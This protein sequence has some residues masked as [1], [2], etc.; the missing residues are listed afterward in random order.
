MRFAAMAMLFFVVGTTPA[1]AIC[2]NNARVFSA[3]DQQIN[4]TVDYL[5]CLHNELAATINQNAGLL[6]RLSLRVLALEDQ[7]DARLV[8]RIEALESLVID[9]EKRALEFEARLSDLESA[10]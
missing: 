10:N 2:I 7:G 5:I 6:D 4:A 3:L 9:A 1:S 8:A